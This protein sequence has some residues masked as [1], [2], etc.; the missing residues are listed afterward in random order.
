MKPES[1]YNMLIVSYCLISS[2][3]RT[4]NTLQGSRGPIRRTRMH[5]ASAKKKKRLFK[6]IECVS[7]VEGLEGVVRELHIKVDKVA[8]YVKSTRMN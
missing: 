5:M 1:L 4:L 2:F 6:L 3:L 8:N 7:K